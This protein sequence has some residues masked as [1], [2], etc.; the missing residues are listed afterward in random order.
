M[1]VKRIA[2]GEVIERPASV[3]KELME[4]AVDA[5]AARINL[6]VEQGGTALI[7]IAD[8][9]C[10]IS[11]DDLA[12]AV[13]PHATSK[14]QVEDDL[15]RISSLGFRG[16]ALASIGA[17]SKLRILSKTRECDQ[18]AEIVVEAEQVRTDRAAGCP[19][20]TTVEVR[21]LFFNVPARRKFLRAAGTEMG[22]VNTQ[23]T[24]IALAHPHIALEL[25]SNTRL[26]HRLPRHTDRLERIA[27]FYSPELADELLAFQREEAGL[28]IEGYAAPPASARSSANWQMTF[29]NGRYIRDKFIQHAIRESFRGLIDPH[30]H[31]IVWL[32]LNIDPELVDVNVHPTKIEVR[33]RD[34]QVVHSQVLSILR[35]TLQSADLTPALGAPRPARPSD[36]TMTP[37]AS[38]ELLRGFAED[39][40]RTPPIQP[41]PFPGPRGSAGS[42]GQRYNPA[43]TGSTSPS[44]LVQGT[45]VWRALYTPAAEADPPG[46]PRPT[47]PAA[48]PAATDRHGS[49]S[50]GA[51][52][53]HNTYLVCETDDGMIIIDQHALHERILF[54]QL[55]QRIATGKLESQRLLLPETIPVTEAQA[56][57]LETHAA[58]LDRIGLEVTRFGT[59]SIAIH[60]A[61]ALLGDTA[62]AD[63]L[64]DLLD[65][66]TD[67]P[68]V[69]TDGPQPGPGHP[70]GEGAPTAAP[71]TE[72]I[73]YDLLS[74]MACK[75]A[76]KAGDP[77][78][79]EEIQ[80]LVSRK[81][82]VEKSSN[83][84]HGRP[85]TLRF[86]TKDLERQF[87]R[88]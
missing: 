45:D 11:A 26:V 49:P 42:A 82:L 29:L 17:V 10:G 60:S 48:P 44:A 67:R 7:R 9:G 46:A 19:T 3:V 56:A 57:I 55:K 52:Q 62:A 80:A 33:W 12:L 50:G 15:Y 14:L 43:P 77:L 83:C 53:L 64:R 22:H 65:N 51:I 84:P 35:E 81:D 74:M 23:F 8:D 25:K 61:P 58:L 72:E 38:T 13:A 18:G 88:T 79:Q 37:Q 73:L 24:R 59:D 78:T 21:D 76:V 40:K 54:E 34:S 68:P 63:F 36:N 41:T 47:E 32:F 87:K 70:S 31:P 27:K 71:A 4:N 2:A 6:T 28:A 5:G 69:H 75:A 20:G 85:T 86:T 66:L 39:L 16:E 1:L 30:R